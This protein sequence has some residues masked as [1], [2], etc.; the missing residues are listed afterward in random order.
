MT[1]K[2]TQFLYREST[3]NVKFCL[4]LQLTA[5]K[6]PFEKIGPQITLKID[7]KIVKISK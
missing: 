2:L 3:L 7:V 6:C 4:H 1:V 5:Q